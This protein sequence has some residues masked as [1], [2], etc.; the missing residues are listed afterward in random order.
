M[1]ECSWSFLISGRNA[2][3]ILRDLTEKGGGGASLKREDNRAVCVWPSVY[4]DVHACS[5]CGV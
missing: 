2:K 5:S 3:Q 1:E 4:T